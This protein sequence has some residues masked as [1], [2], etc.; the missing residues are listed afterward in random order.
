PVQ[1]ARSIEFF[2]KRD[3]MNIENLGPALVSQLVDTGL[4]ADVADLY[5]ITAPQLVELERMGQKS[6]ENVVAA[7]AGSKEKATLSRLLIGLG[8]P[9]IGEVWA[10]A[11]AER[12]GDLASL[13]AATPEALHA[14]LL[15]LHGFGE[16]RARA[17]ETFLADPRNRKVLDKLMA[18]GVSPSEPKIERSGPLAGYRLCLTGT[19]S[20]PR[21]EVQA[22]IEAAGGIYDKT[23]KKGTHYL[24]AGADVGATKLKDAQKKGTR[25]IDEAALER[26][27]RGETLETP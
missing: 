4:I 15:A 10:R 12:Y 23:V 6:A 11:V 14:A 24:V 19:L 26:L 20:R 7:I 9:G 18:R 3:A 5:D 8:M 27:L 25:V 17:V 1:R 16:E 13:M 22:A 21:P 2:C